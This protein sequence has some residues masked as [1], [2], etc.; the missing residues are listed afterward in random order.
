MKFHYLARGI[1]FINGK[2]LLVRHLGA[3]NTFLPGGHIRIGEKA[4]DALAR[5]IE[6]EIGNK[7]IVQRFIGAVECT[8]EEN[9]QN[10][11]EI[12]L[13]FEVAIPDIDS[14][15]PPHS[16]ENHLEFYWVEPKELKTY[17]LQ[18]YP[19]VK[20]IMDWKNNY[21]GFWGTTMNQKA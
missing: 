12:N 6:E 19:L 5:E 13:V 14:I 1:N 2:V 11:H 9:N 21:N 16:K 18:P 4:E 8:W 17:N 3:S 20:C 15:N 10:N 7:A